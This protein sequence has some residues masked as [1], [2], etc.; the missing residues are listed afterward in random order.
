MCAQAVRRMQRE[1]FR[2]L[3]GWAR[4][5]L[6]EM[7][8][9]VSAPFTATS[10]TEE[11]LMIGATPAR[12]H[13]LIRARKEQDPH[14]LRWRLFGHH[15][16]RLLAQHG[17]LDLRYLCAVERRRQGD[18]EAGRGHMVLHHRGLCD[19]YGAGTR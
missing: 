4:G 3:R 15:R 1:A 13:R 12:S 6:L 7:G 10:R 19:W 8:R 14:Q 17:A 11:T 18:G 2:T 5:I 16:Q 9:S